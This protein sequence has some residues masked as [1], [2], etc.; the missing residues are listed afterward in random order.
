MGLG[1]DEVG[2]AGNEKASSVANGSGGSTAG[3]SSM[4]SLDLP[5]PLPL[6]FLP[7]LLP[8]PSR[9]GRPPRP[10]R[11]LDGPVLLLLLLRTAVP[12]DRLSSSL[13]G[14]A[15]AA[16]APP[17]AASNALAAGSA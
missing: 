14:A 15:S 12:S 17:S 4:L 7:E 10:S 3:G 13:P 6:L 16:L 11:S 9:E 2:S 1:L 8:L 5:L